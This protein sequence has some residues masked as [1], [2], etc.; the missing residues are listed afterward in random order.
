VEQIVRGN[1]IALLG[2]TG[3]GLWGPS[4]G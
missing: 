2:L 3:E 4:A 1:A